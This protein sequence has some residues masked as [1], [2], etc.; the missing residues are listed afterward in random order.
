MVGLQVFDERDEVPVS[1]ND[2][3]RVE[4]GREPD[5]ALST[6]SKLS[7][8]MRRLERELAGCGDA[9]MVYGLTASDEW[10][11]FARVALKHAP[12]YLRGGDPAPPEFEGLANTAERLVREFESNTEKEPA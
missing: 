10:R 7:A 4:L 6:P 2:D 1:G 12:H 5:S 8:E 9:D 3:H 11:E